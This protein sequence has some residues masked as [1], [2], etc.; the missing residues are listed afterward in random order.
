MAA[1][2]REVLGDQLW[3]DPV[4]ISLGYKS[5]RARKYLYYFFAQCFAIAK[6]SQEQNLDKSQEDQA[7]C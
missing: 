6:F 1:L 4:D 3:S 7:D 5:V 2:F